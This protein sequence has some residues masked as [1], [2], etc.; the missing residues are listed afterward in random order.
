MNKQYNRH[1]RALVLVGLLSALALALS[2]LEMIFTPLL[3]PGA[4]AGLSNIVVMF[5][6]FALGLPQ[7]LAI[8]FVKAALA[9]FTRGI[10]AALFSLS[11]GLA[12][13][14]LLW[15]LYRYT[16]RPGMLG[17]S[18]AGAVCHSATQLLLATLLYG[19]AVL[20]YAPLM[21]LFAIPAGFITAS[22]LGAAQHLIQAF[23]HKE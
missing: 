4:K 7:T 3:P 6:A 22:L 20:A 14:V 19:K 11:G 9:L 15:V 21:L 10:V 2:A 1:A 13:A 18:L 16:K 17:I 8:V 23:L 5:A 12:S